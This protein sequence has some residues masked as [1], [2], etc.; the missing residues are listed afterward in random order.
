LV[1]DGV[2][3]TL[4]SPV[5]GVSIGWLKSDIVSLVLTSL[6]G[7]SEKLLVLSI[8]PGGHEVVADG[9]V[10]L[11]GVD[12]VDLSILLGEEAH[13]ELEFLLGSI[14]DSVFRHVLNES[15]LELELILGDG[16]VSEDSEDV[17]HGENW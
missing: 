8:S 6:S 16:V 4:G 1:L 15:L 11:S 7:I 14:G 10:L 13:S 3:S 17:L 12:L 9:E 2:N 5:D